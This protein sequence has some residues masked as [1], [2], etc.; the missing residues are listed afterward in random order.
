M[1]ETLI[2]E[3]LKKL[4]PKEILTDPEL[5]ERYLDQLTTR[6]FCELAVRGPNN[7]KIYLVYREANNPELTSQQP[8]S[9]VEF[10]Q[11]GKF[12]RGYHTAISLDLVAEN[13]GN[14]QVVG[15]MDHKLTR[16]DQKTVA[17]GNF[18]N[19]RKIFSN[20]RV[21][22]FRTA[23]TEHDQT[24]KLAESG[25]RI[26]PNFRNKKLGKLLAATS[27]L[28]LERQ[29][30]TEIDLSGFVSNDLARTLKRFG[31]SRS[32]G[33][34]LAMNKIMNLDLAAAILP[35]IKK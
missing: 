9:N 35:S 24:M 21:K 18:A 32:T 14:Y 29:G 34:T 33:Q 4:K 7:E 6:G 17:N 1:P 28:M 12:G 15:F 26:E 27:Y 10:L 3:W 31:F 8:I 25:T 5:V 20:H 22:K 23:L 19:Q 13:N 30:V 2:A 16:F 11:K